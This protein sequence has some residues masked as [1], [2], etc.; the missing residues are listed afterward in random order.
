MVDLPLIVYP[1]RPVTWF[2]DTV[3]LNERRL[4]AESAAV[5]RSDGERM[6]REL[7]DN[8]FGRELW[9]LLEPSTRY[10]V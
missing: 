8:L 7:R 3:A 10:I 9:P 6:S 4:W 1:D 5:Y 2:S